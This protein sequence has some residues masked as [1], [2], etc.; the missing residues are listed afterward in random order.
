MITAKTS[1]MVRRNRKLARQKWG[2]ERN[3]P[4]LGSLRSLTED[5]A[6]SVSAGDV[7]LLQGNWCVTAASILRIAKRNRC[8][9]MK[10]Q[11]IRELSD[12]AARRFAFEATVF[13]SKSC[14][15]SS[16]T[17]MPIHRTFRLWSKAQSCESPKPG[18]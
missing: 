10:V 8:S 6:L 4:L 16:V 14:K 1:S 7:I 13:K 17:A 12:P 2:L 15:V 3:Q 11:F 5:L 9:G 18:P